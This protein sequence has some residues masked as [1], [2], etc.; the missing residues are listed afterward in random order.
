MDL[1]GDGSTGNLASARHEAGDVVVASAVEMSGRG[2][3]GVHAR[4]GDASGH[5]EGGADLHE[6]SISSEDSRHEKKSAD[7]F[8]DIC[9]GFEKASVRNSFSKKGAKG[10]RER[11]WCVLMVHRN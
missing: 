6:I 3:G 4:T 2:E 10:E 7:D 8:G 5:C 1:P 11:E 9:C